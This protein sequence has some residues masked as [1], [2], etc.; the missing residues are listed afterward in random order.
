MKTSLVLL[1][2]PLLLTSCEFKCQV[3]G[4]TTPE[5]DKSK[6]VMQDGAAIYNGIKLQ[7]T[8]VKVEKAYLIF[9]NGQRLEEGNFIDFSSPVQLVLLIDEGWVAENGKVLLGAAEKVT[10]EDS[11]KVL[12]D[13]ADLFA[14]YPDGVS[15][16]DAK[17]ISLTATLKFDNPIPPTT[18]T[19]SFKVWDKKGNG[20]I[21]GS[22][23]LHS[24]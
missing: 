5:D 19:T 14:K 16:A 22:Y 3:G 6:P 18:F 17:I 12:L 24:K 20:V 11:G 15:E 13:E 21:E 10:V 8:N 9:E 2:L 7:A 4:K 23:T 1:L